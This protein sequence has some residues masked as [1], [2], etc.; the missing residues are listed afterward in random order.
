MFEC[1]A[2]A[3]GPSQL[4]IDEDKSPRRL[5]EVRECRRIKR[6]FGKMCPKVRLSVRKRDATVV[7][8]GVP[9]AKV[10]ATS[11]VEHSI[12]WNRALLP[13][14]Q[15]NKKDAEAALAQDERDA[16]STVQWG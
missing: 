14:L 11:E 13:N 7:C 9:L 1:D 6:V 5:K 15:T 2:A 12:K 8:D 3:G 16:Q 10:T 4:F